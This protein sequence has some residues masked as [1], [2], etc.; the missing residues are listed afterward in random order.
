[1]IFLILSLSAL[2]I[3]IYDMSLVNYAKIYHFMILLVSITFA[4]I[5]RLIKIKKI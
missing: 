2:L 1:M 4:A 3:G 5:A